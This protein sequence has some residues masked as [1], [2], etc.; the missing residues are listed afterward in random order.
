MKNLRC[1]L[2]NYSR[3]TYLVEN[4]ELCEPIFSSIDC[5]VGYSPFGCSMKMLNLMK[6]FDFSEVACYPEMFYSGLLKPAIVEYFSE[7]NLNPANIFFG[8][9]SF[10]LAERVIHK[11]IVPKS[12]LGYGPQFNEIPTEME[13][14]GG[15]YRPI[16]LTDNFQ[17]P[18]HEVLYQLR[19]DK[20]SLLYLD[21]PNNPTGHLISLNDVECMVKEAEK[22]EI[23]VLVDEAYGDFVANEYSAINLINKHS[24]LIVIRS[25]SKALGLAAQRIGYTIMSDCLVPYFAKVDVPFEP[26]LVSAIMAGAVLGDQKFIDSVRVRSHLVK[27][28]ICEVILQRGLEILPTHPDVSILMVHKPATNLFEKFQKIGI[29][30]ENG[31]SYKRTNF[32]MDSSFVRLRVPN[33]V[34]TQILLERITK[35]V[36]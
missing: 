3:D 10:N 29:N 6:E 13:A 32:I 20:D 4:K 5:E 14:A 25:F 26:T 16:Q 27:K 1:Q 15:L 30:V 22:N 11:L 23:I 28:Q 35:S 24:N 9:G 8:H 18:L 19:S 2:A 34:N 36:F 12:M 17:F 7:A 21:N 33:E 31:V